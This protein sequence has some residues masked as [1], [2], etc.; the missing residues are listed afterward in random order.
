MPPVKHTCNQIER[1]L[2]LETLLDP[3][4]GIVMDKLESLARGQGEMKKTMEDFIKSV[5]IKYVKKET[6][7]VAVS[8]L[9]A[10]AT[11]IWVVTRAIN[12]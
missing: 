12:K 2:K 7:K 11:F 4:T 3:E 5:D 10:I 6:F 9:W 1:I 8:V